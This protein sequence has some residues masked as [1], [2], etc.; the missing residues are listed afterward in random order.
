[1]N[2][3]SVNNNAQPAI[4][5]EIV[6]G[7]PPADGFRDTTSQPR[8]IERKKPALLRVLGW[9]F[10]LI[11]AIVG[12]VVSIAFTGVIVVV[13]AVLLGLALLIFLLWML[14]AGNA[15]SIIKVRRG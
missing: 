7:P 5:P 14:L 4:E 11:C 10:G 2:D 15:K 8:R 6:V 13:G 1:M 3:L 9:I 12:A